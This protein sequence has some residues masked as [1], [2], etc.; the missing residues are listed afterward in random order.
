MSGRLLTVG[1]QAVN[2]EDVCDTIRPLT[3]RQFLSSPG[4]VE[5]PSHNRLSTHSA[6]HTMTVIY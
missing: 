6:K 2:R 4:V 5:V 1:W 3:L